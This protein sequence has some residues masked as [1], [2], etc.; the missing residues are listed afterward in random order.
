MNNYKRGQK[1]SCRNAYSHPYNPNW[2]NNH[3]NLSWGNNNNILQPQH[4]YKA[5]EKKMIVEDMFGKQLEEIK[6]NNN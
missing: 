6:K 2:Q 4:N 5:P 3:P 1:Y